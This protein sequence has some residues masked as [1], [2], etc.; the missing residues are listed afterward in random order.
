MRR[1]RGFLLIFG[2][3]VL[4]VLLILGLGFLGKQADAYRSATQA[5]ASS[6]ALECAMA[7]LEDA[8][9]KLMKDL[10]FPPP[11]DVE[12]L[13]FAY[14]EVLNDLD[15][16]PVGAY[17]VTID[18]RWADPPAEILV[19]EVEGSAGDPSQPGQAFRTLRVE[20][21]LAPQRGGGPNPNLGRFINFQDLGGL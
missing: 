15:G 7:G 4:V 10:R 21:D 20:W 5:A 19:V 17:T 12:Q 3:L 13:Q 18:S 6:V 14:T 2:L 8:R 9:V 1:R 16:T 11:G